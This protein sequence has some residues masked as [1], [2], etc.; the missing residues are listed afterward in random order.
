[1]YYNNFEI[2]FIIFDYLIL[3]YDLAK[4]APMIGQISIELHRRLL[5]NN[6]SG[7]QVYRFI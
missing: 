2:H 6:V 5:F 3:S 7:R 1:M 4:S